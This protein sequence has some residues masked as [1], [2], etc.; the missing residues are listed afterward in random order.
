MPEV[1]QIH[2]DVLRYLI[3]KLQE[4]ESPIAL[5]PGFFMGKEVI[6]V[7]EVKE[8]AKDSVKLKPLVVL[9]DNTNIE[10]LLDNVGEPFMTVKEEDD[11]ERDSGGDAEAGDV[12][13]PVSGTD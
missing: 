1:E 8:R 2:Y 9:L 6:F 4:D 3:Y 7:A 10:C 5:I 11:G 12:P 13:S